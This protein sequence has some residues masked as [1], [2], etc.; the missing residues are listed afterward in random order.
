M[1]TLNSTL[2]SQWTAVVLYKCNK[3]L[4]PVALKAGEQVVGWLE[5]PYLLPQIELF[6]YGLVKCLL[7]RLKCICKSLFSLTKVT[8]STI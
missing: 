8:G 5:S 7:Y 1:C 6:A 2:S 4:V 3:L